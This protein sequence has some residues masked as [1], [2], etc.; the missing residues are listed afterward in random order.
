MATHPHDHHP[1]VDSPAWRRRLLGRTV[2]GGFATLSTVGG[3]TPWA[4]PERYGVARLED[5]AYGPLPEHRLD[6]YRPQGPGPFPVAVY[7]HGGG[8]RSLSKSTHW[9]MA[10]QFAARGFL[11]LCVEYRLAP[12]NPYPAAVQDVCLAL[13]WAAANA[14]AHGGDPQRLV[15]AGES[16]GGNLALAGT[17][18]AVSPRPEP[19]ARRLH[20]AGVRPRAC[21]PLCGILQVSDPRRFQRRKRIP[22][23]LQDVIDNCATAYLPVD[24]E[25]P[26]ADPLL[27]V[28]R[29]ELHAPDGWPAFFVSCGTADPILDDSRRLQAALEARGVPVEGRWYPG[30]VHAFQGLLWRRQ[31]R[32]HWR[33]LFDFLGPLMAL[34]PARS[35]G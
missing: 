18:A 25:H 24:A 21:V 14:E 29:E 11:T 27:V 34:E 32:Q 10:L 6:V 2:S 23:W 4:R 7:V 19:W 22:F 20:E 8:F 31:A 33:E 35:A 28:E 1:D 16:A 5:L 17:L 13:E 12:H 26:L 30:E 3:R 9:P 15:V